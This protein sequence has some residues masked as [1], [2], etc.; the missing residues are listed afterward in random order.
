MIL[1]MS[2]FAFAED[3]DLSTATVGNPD[4]ASQQA[5][6]SFWDKFWAGFGGF[7]VVGGGVCSSYPDYSEKF[8]AKD[9]TLCFRNDDNDGWRVVMYNADPWGW[10]RTKDIERGDKECFYLVKGHKYHYDL[11]YCDPAVSKSCTETD[12]GKDYENRGK[13]TFTVDG[14]T[15]VVSDEC[16]LPTRL[17]ERY[18]DSDGSLASILKDCVCKDGE[19]VE[20]ITYTPLPTPDEKNLVC[21]SAD[22]NLCDNAFPDCP[23]GWIQVKSWDACKELIEKNKIKPED[24][25]WC[26]L[27][28]YN[29]CE[30][31]YPDCPTNSEEVEGREVC[32]ALVEGNGILESDY[33]ACYSTLT[34]Y[35]ELISYECPRFWEEFP[36]IEECNAHAEE[37]RTP[38]PEK[39][40][41]VCLNEK[42]GYC[43]FMYPECDAGWTKVDGNMEYCNDILKNMKDNK[44]WCYDDRFKLCFEQDNSCGLFE[45]N[46]YTRADCEI[47]N[48]TLNWW[49]QVLLRTY[50]WVLVLLAV[51]GIT[52]YLVMRKKKGRKR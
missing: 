10:I 42:E 19:C 39:D 25:K 45:K 2:S 28:D 14:D 1:V 16:Y 12:N 9:D 8:T 36:S 48:K 26:Y 20:D 38:I 37:M 13:T 49:T 46:Y 35:C 29:L 21:Y 15:M 44:I 24:H 6:L 30:Q 3:A 51:A 5:R 41:I 52:I 4:Y 40:Y 34:G 33:V 50:W 11:Y 32:L 31:S 43:E 23:D 22:Y 47:D 7:T 17:Q 27:R 18:C